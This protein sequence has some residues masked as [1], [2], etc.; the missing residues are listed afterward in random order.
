MSFTIWLTGLP[1]SGKTTI[2]VALGD[3]LQRNGLA[4]EILDG[5][6]VR[7]T[8]CSDLG[9]SPEDR[10][11]NAI[12]VAYICQILNKHRIISV[13]SLITPYNHTR[14]EIRLLLPRLIEVY[15]SCPIE[16]LMKRDP[17]GL[18]RRAL[19]GEIEN[20]T[21]ISAPYEIPESPDVVVRTDQASVCECVRSIIGTICSKGYLCNT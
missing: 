1:G 6:T 5:D 7:K 19:E 17:K 2:A 8:L 16:I 3:F 12:R 14:K 4:Y 18:Y 13:V 10:K 11:I 20:F 15:V 9:Y 21:G